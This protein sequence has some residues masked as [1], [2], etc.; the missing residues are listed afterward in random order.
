MTN[1]KELTHIDLFSGIG[2]FTLAAEWAGFKT[3]VFCEKEKFCQKILEARFKG[4]VAD[5]KCRRFKENC[6]QSHNSRTFQQG[7]KTQSKKSKIR[8]ATNTIRIGIKNGIPIIPEIRD[9]D[10][11]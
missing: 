10:G 6:R 7:R 11:T 8:R 3:V 2:G 5:S 9:F 4:I 1:E